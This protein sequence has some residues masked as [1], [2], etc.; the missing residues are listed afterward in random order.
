MFAS[1]LDDA[2]ATCAQALETGIGLSDACQRLGNLLQGVG[3]F[4][5]AVVWRT[6]ALQPQPNPA[7]IYAGFGKL[8]ASQARWREAIAAYEQALSFEPEN[9]EI[10][11]TLAGM[12]AQVGERIE[13]V[14]YRYQAVSLQPRWAN[15]KNQLVLGNALIEQGKVAEA[16]DCYQRAVQLRPD[17]YEAYYNLGVALAEQEAWQEAIAAFTRAL[18]IN[19]DHAASHLGLAKLLDEQGDLTTALTHYQQAAALDPESAA[20]PYMLAEALLKLRQWQAALAPCRR[21]AELNPDFA[22]AHHYLGYALLKQGQWQ[23]ATVALQRATELNATSPW[24]YY[25]LGTAYIHLKQWQASATASL[26]AIRLQ[27][28]LAGIYQQLG[29]ALRQQCQ[30]MELETVVQ[31]YR[32][33]Q[34][35]LQ[36]WLQI[37]NTLMAAQQFLGAVVGYRMALALQPEIIQPLLD[38]AIAQQQQL[39]MMIGAYRQQIQQHPEQAWNYTHLGNLLADQGEREAAIGLH[40]TASVLQGWQRAASRSYEFT[41]DWFTHNIPIWRSVLQPFAHYPGV[42]ALEIG[43]FEGM[44]ACWLLDHILTHPTANLTC[45]DRYFQEVFQTNVGQTGASD[46]VIQLTG[47]SHSILATLTADSYD[48]IYIDGCHLAAHVQQDAALSWRLLK[49]GGLLI[50]DDYAWTD[51]NHPGEDTQIGINAFIQSVQGQATIVHHAYQLIIRK[52]QAVDAGAVS[53]EAVSMNSELV[54]AMSL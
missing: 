4:Q 11:R 46:R 49:L 15:P 14:M 53:A 44:S 32:Q 25:H 1:R 19:P 23:E 54:S 3:N 47:D 18:T 41:H 22:W 31:L 9:A 29:A 7:M 16:I 33:R 20:A 2:I 38:Q 42:N 26:N 8:Y 43:S 13:E 39:D 17:F 35:S 30:A 28:D 52:I 6:R 37:A 40:Q 21:A 34:E 5:D 12:Y 45:I 36:D 51:P 27:A 24:T 50:F 10:H 48:L